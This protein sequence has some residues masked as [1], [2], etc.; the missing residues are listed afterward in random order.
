MYTHRIANIKNKANRP[1]AAYFQ[2]RR[3]TEKNKLNPTKKQSLKMKKIMY[4]D[5]RTALNQGLTPS[6][7]SKHATIREKIK[8]RISAYLQYP[9]D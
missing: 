8:K 4:F 1:R 6:Q 2:K 9:S 7:T 3:K 5:I